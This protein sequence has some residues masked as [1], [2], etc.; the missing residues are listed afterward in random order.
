M[1]A[2]TE[3]RTMC[4]HSNGKFSPLQL[5]PVTQTLPRKNRPMM[6]LF[7]FQLPNGSS[8]LRISLAPEIA[9]AIPMIERDIAGGRPAV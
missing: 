9:D 3:R 4:G 5:L 6:D 7:L 8:K 2:A 1:I